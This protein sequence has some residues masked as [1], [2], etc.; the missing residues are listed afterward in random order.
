[1][2][3]SSLSV[4]WV[5]CKIK[6]E[7]HTS[8]HSVAYSRLPALFVSL[9]DFMSATQAISAE[10]IREKLYNHIDITTNTSNH[11]LPL[12]PSTASP[13]IMS[14]CH[15]K[16]TPQCGKSSSLGPIS[17]PESIAADH[18][19]PSCLG[20]VIAFSE[21]LK[22]PPSPSTP[23]HMDLEIYGKDDGDCSDDSDC[24]KDRFML[25]DE[26]QVDIE[27]LVSVTA[28][29]AYPRSSLV[30]TLA[31]T[32][33][34]STPSFV[35]EAECTASTASTSSS[36]TNASLDDHSSHSNSH[37][38]LV[39]SCSSKNSFSTG[40]LVIWRLMCMY[41]TTYS[42]LFNLNV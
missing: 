41:D 7:C 26:A 22:L 9:T 35:S 12:S 1:M 20:S 10:A 28:C 42:V 5:T 14:P 30:A 39:S 21:P 8:T 6:N 25:T 31:Y 36:S 23:A 24:T 29:N 38:S 27:R 11:L 19:Q 34:I 17:W 15:A 32:R 33:S 40:E 2:S 37:G 16:Q 4:R 13:E 18:N 3:A